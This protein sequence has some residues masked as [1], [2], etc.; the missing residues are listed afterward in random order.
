MTKKK[1]EVEIIDPKQTKI[2]DWYDKLLDDLWELAQTKVIE[3]KHQIG[4]RILE[5]WDKFGKPEYGNKF[6]ETLAKDLQISTTNIYD[7]IKFARLFPKL[8]EFYTYVAEL[9]DSPPRGKI[10]W[11]W[12]RKELLPENKDDGDENDIFH[13]KVYDVW[14]FS[15][16]DDRFGIEYPGRIPGQIIQNILYYYTKENDIIVD[17][18]AG[19]G[20]TND[21]CKYTNRKCYSYDINPKR[22]F[23]KKH[24]ITK[25]FPSKLKD[26][27]LIILDPPYYKKKE[28][29]YGENA[30]SA[31]DR[32]QYLDAIN[33]I[34]INCKGNKIA[35]IMGKYYDYDNPRD[36]I[37]L[38]DYVKIFESNNFKQINEISINQTPPQG[39]Q[40]AVKQAKEKQRMEI[41]KRDLVIFEW[42][43]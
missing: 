16:C 40:F 8:E 18:M 6:I 28:D 21:V 1:Q 29:E 2:T 31:F 42:I 32:K 22:D 37:F 27:S 24:D 33:K 39:G 19:G 30:I 26:I 11:R 3:F 5:D 34:A 23:I 17:P 20:V 41:I 13:P 36:S 10:P 12:I 4:K 9:E 25:S 7:C 15:E 35:F 43:G 38:S 14:N